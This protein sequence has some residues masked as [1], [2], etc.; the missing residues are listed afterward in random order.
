L[1]FDEGRAAQD[2]VVPRGGEVR[3]AIR[4]L[5]VDDNRVI[6]DQ[7]GQLLSEEF[8][9][10]GVARDGEEMIEAA[11]RLRPDVIVAD[12]AMPLLDGI[13]ASRRILQ[14]H[15]ETLIVLLTMHREPAL[16]RRAFAAGVRAYVHKLN[17][18][19][20]I[21]KA[22]HLVL[23]GEIFVSPSCANPT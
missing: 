13:E 10:A 9:V 8:E 11:E 22:V 14:N 6:L 23:R 18:V 4:L 15:P 2:S 12:I 20:E 21:A 5:I 1:S 7:L 3:L 17:A 16:V 19:E